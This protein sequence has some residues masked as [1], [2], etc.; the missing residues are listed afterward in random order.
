VILISV[1]AQSDFEDLIRASAVA[2]F[3]AKAELSARA[4]HDVLGGEA[5]PAPA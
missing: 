3:V 2:G 5:D 1:H 4:I